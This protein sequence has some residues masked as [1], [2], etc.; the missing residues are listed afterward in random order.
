MDIRDYKQPER[1][2]T[3]AELA[4]INP[5]L[6]AIQKILD[7]GSL[8]KAFRPHRDSHT[9]TVCKYLDRIEFHEDCDADLVTMLDGGISV[10]SSE[11]TFEAV[12]RDTTIPKTE[13]HLVIALDAGPHE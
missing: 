7:T 5:N 10:L 6:I 1:P 13:G 2:F 8:V 4:I 11:Y 12:P 3:E 9:N